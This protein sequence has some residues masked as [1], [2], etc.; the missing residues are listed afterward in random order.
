MENDNAHGAAAQANEA[1]SKAPGAQPASSRSQP[2]NKPETKIA[3]AYQS[4]SIASVGIEMGIAVL[5]GWAI[6][7]FLDKELG[8]YPYLTLVFLGVGIAA[9]FRALFRA[10]RQAKS[11]SGESDT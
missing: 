1:K 11:M 2:E 6:G 8:T 7:H 10:A 5:V 9:G 3:R 4:L